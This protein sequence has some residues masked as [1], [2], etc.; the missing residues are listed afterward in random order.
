MNK[1]LL[2][3]N[4]FLCVTPGTQYITIGGAIA[5]DIHGKNHHNDGSFS[6]HVLE[7]DVLL[8]NGKIKKCSKNKNSK[9]FYSTCGGMGLTGILLSAK[10]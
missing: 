1:R 10:I 5:S 3:K 8:A 7:C 2:N 6:D 4:L 9:L